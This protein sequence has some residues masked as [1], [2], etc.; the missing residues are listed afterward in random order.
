MGLIVFE[1]LS[2]KDFTKYGRKIQSAQLSPARHLIDTYLITTELQEKQKTPN[3]KISVYSRSKLGSHPGC[4][5]KENCHTKLKK[6][7]NI[8]HLAAKCH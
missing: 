8:L 7:S 3:N 5:Y 2:F 6:I 4:P 1:I